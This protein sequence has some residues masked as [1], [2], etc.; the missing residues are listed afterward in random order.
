[1]DDLRPVVEALERTS[2]S[3]VVTDPEWRIAWSSPEIALI[4][5]EEGA[6]DLAVGRHLLDTRALGAFRVVSEDA[7][8]DWVRVHAPF[9]L[10]DGATTREELAEL[11][12]QRFRSIVEEAEPRPAPLRWTV[13]LSLANEEEVGVVAHGERVI[14]PDGRLLGNAFMYGSALPASVLWQVNQGDQRMFRRLAE[15][16]EPGRRPA[17][18]LFADLAGSTELSKRMS[19][20]AYFGLIRRL[21]GGADAAILDAGGIVGK[22]AGDG[23]SAFFLADQVGSSPRAALAALRAGRAVQVA[24]AQE[25]VSMNVAIHWGAT[26][27]IG[28]VATSG[29]LEVTAL[30]D[31]VNECARIQEAAHG[32]TLLATKAL[33]ERLEPEDARAEGVDPPEL[34]YTLVSE[35]PD[36]GEKAIRDAG[37]IAVVDVS[38]GP[39]R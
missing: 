22:H 21:T 1:V 35:L 10:H 2:W 12:D 4:I 26:L 27:Y 5:G 37:G 18:V 16:V 7:V 13:S 19:S 33:I 28:Q 6:N 23:V 11:V 38:V 32:G 17:A 36:A 25:E 29:R 20:A 30:G 3:A 24:A 15:L 31:E 8:G 9:V 14:A 34:R 39:T